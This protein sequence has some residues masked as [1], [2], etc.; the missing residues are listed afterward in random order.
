M[1]SL[2]KPTATLPV[3]ARVAVAL[4]GG[5]DSS[6]A[7]A[8]LKEQGYD[9]IGITLR[10]YEAEG[11][12]SLPDA[13]IVAEKLGIE[14]K[15]IDLRSV[16]IEEIIKPFAETYAHGETPNPCAVCNR[17]IKFGALVKIAHELGAQFIATGHYA[18]IVDGKNGKELHMAKD[19]ERDQS[20]FLFATSRDILPC[21]LFPLGQMTKN[22]VREKAAT[23]GLP[24]AT[25]P[26]S[27]DICFVPNGDYIS[28]VKQFYPKASIPGEIVDEHGKVLGKHGGLINFTVGQRR[29]LNIHD[30]TGENNKPLFVIRLE[31]ETNRVVV[32]E[33]ESLAQ[34]EVVL[35]DVNW[36]GETVPLE[37][38]PVNV[39]LRYAMSPIPAHFF[40]TEDKARGRIILEQPAYGI[41]PGQAGVIYFGERVLGGGWIC[42]KTNG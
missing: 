20:Y 18:R 15:T 4:S 25:K 37:G 21:L 39:K 23:L 7:A 12:P 34:T 30:R 10:L 36:L 9:I 22:E 31:P 8:I 41:A 6:I 29:G 11:A 3:R 26:D 19:P 5:V 2:S 24:V 13:K 42:R 32:G 40:L 16:F 14:H 1:D 27:Q 35:R 28:V 33:R 17:K 38:I